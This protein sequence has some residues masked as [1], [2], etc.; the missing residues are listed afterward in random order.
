MAEVVRAALVQAAWTGD[1]E[2][3]TKAH[4]D[5]ARQAAAAGAQVICFQEL[6]YGPYFCQLQD[7]KFYEYAESV[8]GPT[9]ERFQALAAELGLVMVLPVYEQEQPGVLYNTA[10][11]IDAD[12][13]YL[14]KYRKNHIPQVKGF[15]EKF[16][17]RPGNL[18]YPVFDTAVGRIGVY[19]CY[20]RHFP[21]GWRAL[22]LA[23]AKIVFN[24]SAT[25]RGLSSYLWKLEQPASA[26][27]N[28]YF[29]GAINR[30]GVEEFGDNDFYGSSY[31]V[32]PEG[33][34]VG[35]VGHDHDPELIVR[36]LDLSLLDTVRD[37]WQFYRDRRPD[38]YGDLTKP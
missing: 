35:D 16:Y 1:Q 17:F 37:R 12:G 26:V 22:G 29:I 31:F 7:P 28:E 13:K 6:F 38:S 33:K 14:G 19:I 9:V 30:V 32:D 4:E 27:A 20:D 23:G 21:E 18:G 24:P 15:W 36:D 25:S 11:V 34:F 2:S 5:Y 10:A 3:M 8:P